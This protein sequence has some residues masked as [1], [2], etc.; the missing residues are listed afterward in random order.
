MQLGTLTLPDNF[1][2]MNEFDW[3]AVAQ[4]VERSLTGSLVVSESQKTYGR[5]IVLGDGE[6]SWLTLSKVNALFAL[7]AVAGQKLALT[8]PDGRT[9]TVIFDRADGAPIE[10]QPL[11][12]LTVPSSAPSDGH[13]YSVV[14]RLMT[15]AAN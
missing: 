10:A 9:Y 15:V 1:V 2:W 4:E 14:I 5:P 12:P 6:N 13:F 7:S 11:F 3:S 8:L